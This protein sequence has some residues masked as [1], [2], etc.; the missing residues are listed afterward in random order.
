MT[1]NVNTNKD[2]GSDSDKARIEE[3]VIIETKDGVK[4][5]EVYADSG[6]YDGT[7]QNAILTDIKGNFYRD[8]N[9][10]LSFDAPIAVYTSK[11]K[12]IRLKGGTR[13]ATKNDVL[14][15]A[16]ELS[17]KGSQDEIVA[18]GDVKI[19]KSEDLLITSDSSIF[20]TDFTKIKL[21]GNSFT[22]VYKK[23]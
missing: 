11:D 13:A 16:K 14:I 9:V 21:K 8:G 2:S 19:R 22:N 7:G 12:E 23:N 3:L 20:N 17:W 6:Y 4:F 15:T 5:W 18:Q 10:V 1:R